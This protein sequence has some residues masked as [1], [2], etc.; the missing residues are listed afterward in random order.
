MVTTF[1]D[2]VKSALTTSQIKIQCVPNRDSLCPKLNFALSQNEERGDRMPRSARERSSTNIYHLMGRGINR[3]KIFEQTR[4]K[5]NFKRLLNKH[6]EKY[7]I[8]IFSYVIM[9]THFH[10]LARADLKLL[11]GYLAIVL[12]EYAEYY[13]FKHDRNG[14][15]FQNRFKSECVESEQ[16]FWNCLRYIHMNPVNANLVKSPLDYKY[17]SIKE[18]QIEKNKI[19]HPAAIKMYKQNFTDF[20]EYL[21]FHNKNQKYIFLD[22]PDDVE[23][24]L[25]K[26]AMAIL[27]Q[28]A[29]LRGFEKPVEMIEN[30]TLRRMYK[31]KLQ[32]ELKISKARTDRLYR[33]VKSC[34]IG[35]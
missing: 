11:S 17:S 31:E 34:I 13:N 20:E 19:I 12:A 15:V 22:T 5:N 30:L 26:V 2:V 14:H 28:E 9:S 35:K 10:L 8:E 27:Y 1:G 29:H 25:Y 23:N 4:E 21:E 3:E 7:G 18:Y 24:Q 32:K 6:L 33:R 16:Y